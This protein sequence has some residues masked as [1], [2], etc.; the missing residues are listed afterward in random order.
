VLRAIAQPVQDHRGPD[1]PELARDI[2]G[3][4]K[5]LIGTDAHV[6]VYPSSGTGAWEASLV[7]TLSPGNKI[8][9]YETGQFAVEWVEVARRLG[10]EIDFLPG[11]WR[12]GVDAAQIEERL[13][14]DSDH[15]FKAVTVVHNETSTGVVSD[16]PA[17]RAAIDRAG[18]PALLLVDTISSLG[19]VK[20]RH[21]EWR[22][23]V[24]ISAS[25]K[26]LML[27]AGLGIN[28]VSEKAR[29]ASKSAKLPRSYWDWE[30]M[31]VRNEDGYFPY[32]P[33]TN[34]LFGLSE[35]L[36]MMREEGMEAM[37]CRQTRL[38]AATREA[39]TAWGLEIQCADPTVYS[40]VLTGVRLPEG[41]DAD[42]FRALT[43]DR[44]DLSLGAGLGK[45]RGKM[46]RIGHLG[47]F[48][49]LML[50][51]TLAGVESGLALSGVPIRRGGVD[52][53]IQSLEKAPP[54]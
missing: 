37:F 7:N 23:D 2:L 11:D 50:F 48:N 52:A 47:D 33:A 14:Q 4:L 3:G 42:R 36:A 16:I 39:V 41:H 51:G 22:V 5:W 9:A 32:T 25:Q 40:P 54:A 24:T 26:G 43:L 35:A 18:H 34:L 1:F 13:R 28:A 31:I 44:F 17:V 8:L 6:V 19:S 29:E 15:Q 46:F 45:L 49:E 53:A 38:A 30:K 12:G 10:L 21:D 20:Y 27:P